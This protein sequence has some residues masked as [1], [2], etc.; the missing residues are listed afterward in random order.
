MHSGEIF[1]MVKPK[2]LNQKMIFGK[3]NQKVKKKKI[4]FPPQLIEADDMHRLM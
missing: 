1:Q 2:G 4:F 3:M